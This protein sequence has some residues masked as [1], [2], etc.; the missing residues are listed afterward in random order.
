MR[1]RSTSLLTS[2]GCGSRGIAASHASTARARLDLAGD[3]AP[4]LTTLR[5]PSACATSAGPAHRRCWS[6]RSPG[7][8]NQRPARVHPRPQLGAGRRHARPAAPRRLRAT[9]RHGVVPPARTCCAVGGGGLREKRAFLTWRATASACRAGQVPSPALSWAGCPAATPPIWRWCEARPTPSCACCA[10][11]LRCR[12][13]VWRQ[14][15]QSVPQPPAASPP[16]GRSGSCRRWRPA[17]SACLALRRRRPQLGHLAR[18]GAGDLPLPPR[19]LPLRQRIRPP[20]RPRPRILA[21]FLPRLTSGRWAPA[22]PPTAPSSTSY[23]PTP[24]PTP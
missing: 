9:D 5:R 4:S 23:A 1:T 15:D 18:P 7:P 24:A 13:L 12:H 19:P 2:R 8:S 6:A 17:V 16:T 14:R 3:G 22:G 21:R 11:T 20:G 10:I